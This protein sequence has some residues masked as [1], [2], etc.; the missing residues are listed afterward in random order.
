VCGD[1]WYT[2]GVIAVDTTLLPARKARRFADCAAT[3]AEGRD[4]QQELARE[5]L[6]HLVS[7]HGC[8]KVGKAAKN[9]LCLLPA[10]K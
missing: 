7:R 1:L 6:E 5:I 4:D 2:H 10:G 8:T 3:L 9:K